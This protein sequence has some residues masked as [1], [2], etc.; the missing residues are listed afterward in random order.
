MRASRQLEAALRRPYVLIGALTLL[1][2]PLLWGGWQLARLGGSLYYVAA[3]AAFLVVAALLWAR[4]ALADRLYALLLTGTLAWALWESAFSAWSLLPR[5]ALPA[6]LG[7]LFLLPRARQLQSALPPHRF[8]SV[9]PIVSAVCLVGLTVAFLRPTWTRSAYPM[10]PAVTDRSVLGDDWGHYGATLKGTRFSPLTQIDPANVAGLE[11]AWTYRS[12]EPADA[13]T[14]GESTPIKIGDTVYT[15][16]PHNIVVALDAQT[17]A[18]RWRHDPKIDRAIV[19]P[20]KTCRGVSY[21]AAPSGTAECPTRIIGGTID[22]RVYALDAATGAECKGFGRG[23]YVSLLEGIG[24]TEAARVYETSAPTVVQGHIVV[25][26]L[27]NDNIDLDM[28]SGVVRSFD[29]IDGH[30]QW[31]WD[32]GAPERVGAPP[33]GRTYTRS[34]PNAWTTFA[35]DEALGLV[36]VPTGNPSPDMWGVKRRPFDEQF[37]SSIVALDLATGRPRWAFQTVHHD[38][39]DYD[40]AA[41]PTLVELDT[42]SGR[43]PALIQATKRGELFVLDRRTGE[44]IVPVAERAVPQHGLPEDWLS[45]TQP[46]SALALPQPTVSETAMWGVTPLDQLACRIQFRMSRYQGIFTPPGTAPTIEMP[47]LTGVVDW[48]GVS[49]DLDRGILVTNYMSLPWRGRLIPRAEVTKE[50]AA[51]PIATAAKGTPYAWQFGPWLSALQIPCFEPP[52]GSLIAIDIAT[53]HVLWNRPLGTA[54]DSGPFGIPS[55]IPIE[56]GVPALSGTMTTRS[57]LVFIS[58][59]VDQYVRAIDLASGRELWRARLPAGGQATPMTYMAGGR[60]FVVVTAGGQT[61]M[62]TKY[63]DY[64]IAFALPRH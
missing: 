10:P 36:Y 11:V 50:F 63:G 34:T 21:Y 37:G 52:W 41:Q 19:Y 18:V 60:Q 22:S 32:A 47:G 51:S 15:C 12:G 39:W 23:G 57:G 49:F 20:L 16:T 2:L 45:P 61:L 14:A 38:L 3:G 13:A 8:P 35:A 29:A 6:A 42:P 27:V 40:V 1:G 30:L 9:S 44:A 58:G 46:F 43:R 33:E 7:F 5:L 26:S 48:G 59:T 64:T 4:S 25:G 62:R 56:I 31:A 17:G 28:P 55:H 24:H 54:V 53:Q